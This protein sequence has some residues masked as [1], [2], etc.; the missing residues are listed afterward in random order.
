MRTIPSKD[1]TTIAFDQSGQWPALILVEGMFEQRALDTETAQLAALPL[2][3]QHF[4]VFH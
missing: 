3:M 2:M 4:T 1:E